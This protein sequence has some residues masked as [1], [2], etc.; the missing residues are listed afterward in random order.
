MRAVFD[1]LR[2]SAL[3][4]GAETHLWARA[5]EQAC[6]FCCDDAAAFSAAPLVPDRLLHSLVT[7]AG[8]D[9]CAGLLEGGAW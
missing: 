4:L 5:S 9:G 6:I 2:D 1:G 8:M 3:V 7:W